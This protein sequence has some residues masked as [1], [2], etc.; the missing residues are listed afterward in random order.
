VMSLWS[1]DAG[2]HNLWIPT[3]VGSG[4]TFRS[5]DSS[6]FLTASGMTAGSKIV[7]KTLNNG[8]EQV[9]DLRP[10]AAAEQARANVRPTTADQYPALAGLWQET[11]GIS[12][13]ITQNAEQFT[14]DCAYHDP[15]NGD[16]RWQMKGIVT[17]EGEITGRLVHTKAPPTWGDPARVGMLSANGATISGRARF[18]RGGGHDFVWRRLSGNAPGPAKVAEPKG[19]IDVKLLDLVKLKL[20]R[21]PAGQFWMG[22]P[23]GE[24]GREDNETQH[25]EQILQEFFIGA[26][27]ITQ[28]QWKAVMGADNNP[29][30]AKGDALPVEMASWDETQVFLQRR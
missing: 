22:S 8:D 10:L 27:E 20:V 5:H 28:A 14:A 21:L 29:S 25:E 6:R 18:D 17:K 1:G 23:A 2:T 9:W 7:Q 11:A 13:T 3:K 30:N 16:I 19:T 24:P 15:Q 26:H 12:F 4:Y